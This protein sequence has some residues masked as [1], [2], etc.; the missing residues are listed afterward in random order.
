MVLPVHAPSAT[1]T[2]RSR[3]ASFPIAVSVTFYALR[4][5][6]RKAVRIIHFLQKQLK[7]DDLVG[8]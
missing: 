3:P 4:L 2:L 6:H 8:I 1:I 5:I 7:N